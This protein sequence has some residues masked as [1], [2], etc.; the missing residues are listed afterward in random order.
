M[1]KTYI[2]PMLSMHKVELQNIIA[3]SPLTLNDTNGSGEL[4]DV[5]ATGDAMGHG[6]SI[7]DEE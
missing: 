5:E 2:I 7:W 1:K 6:S 4:Q 3:A